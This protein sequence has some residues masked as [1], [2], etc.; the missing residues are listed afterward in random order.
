MRPDDLLGAAERA[1]RLRIGPLDARHALERLREFAPPHR[2]DAAGATD[3]LLDWRKRH[4]LV[5][6]APRLVRQA[7]G[8]RVERQ[9]VAFLRILGGGPALDDMQAQVESVAAGDVAHALATAPTDTAT[10]LFR[11]SPLAR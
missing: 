11:E 8:S 1:R 7:A 6:L 2:D 3:I 10:P 9:D 4:W 5:A